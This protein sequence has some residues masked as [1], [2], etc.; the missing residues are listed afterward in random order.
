MREIVFVLTDHGEHGIGITSP[1]APGLIGGVASM[2][3]ATPTHLLG[4]ARE[5]APDVDGFVVFV[6]RL[7]EADGTVFAL[8]CR[9]DFGISARADVATAL[10]ATLVASDVAR[11]GWLGNALGD[12]VAFATLPTDTLGS[13]VDAVAPGEPVTVVLADG[14]DL[15]AVWVDDSADVDRAL[16]VRE[17]ADK[18]ASS[19]TSGARELA[20]A[21]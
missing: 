9:Q 6:E 17:F 16:T 12:V 18:L 14:E 11:E 3:D 15:L 19:R 7:I 20:V 10:E 5:V 1:Q 21:R 8:R 13:V 2:D 4:L